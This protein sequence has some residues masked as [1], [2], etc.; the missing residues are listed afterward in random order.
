MAEM[1]E[2]IA[3]E[4]DSHYPPMPPLL[5]LVS[6]RS[7]Y[8]LARQKS[9]IIHYVHGDTQHD[10]SERSER[11]ENGFHSQ[12]ICFACYRMFQSLASGVT[13]CYSISV[14]EMFTFNP[15]TVLY[16]QTL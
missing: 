16:I 14:E 2:G 15:Q 6:F 1:S 3:I 11:F 5:R 4:N 9:C 10:T 12:R 13:S 7:R 8:A